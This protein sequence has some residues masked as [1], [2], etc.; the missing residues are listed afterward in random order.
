MF[1]NEFVRNLQI[2]SLHPVADDHVVALGFGLTLLPLQSGPDSLLGLLGMGL[3]GEALW[4][5]LLSPFSTGQLACIAC[6]Q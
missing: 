2:N 5:P 3:A 4:V 1:L 6:P